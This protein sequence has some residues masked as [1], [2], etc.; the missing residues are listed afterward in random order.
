MKA[1]VITFNGEISNEKELVREIGSLIVNSKNTSDM[2]ALQLAILSDK[3]VSAL[4]INKALETKTEI[5][6][7]SELETLLRNLVKIVGSPKLAK[8]Q[9]Y[10]IAIINKIPFY[11]ELADIKA[12]S[13][14]RNPTECEKKL[15][16]EYGFENLPNCIDDISDILRIYGY[17]K[18]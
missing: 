2:A 8:S 12:W 9:P 14:L 1:I 6:K 16:I 18:I 4:L 10:K 15:L 13:R 7:I 5:K 11:K 3:E 17:G